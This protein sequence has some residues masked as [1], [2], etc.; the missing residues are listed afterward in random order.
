M[1][2]SVTHAETE[3]L[4]F[5]CYFLLTMDDPPTGAN[6]YQS[7]D[8]KIT[9]QFPSKPLVIVQDRKLVDEVVKLTVA[10]VTYSPLDPEGWGLM[11]YDFKEPKKGKQQR[12]D[13]RD[14]NIDG[15]I[16]ARK[17]K[18]IEARTFVLRE[19]VGKDCFF[20]T[21]GEYHRVQVYVSEHRIIILM[22]KTQS[23][24]DLS[25]KKATDFFGSIIL[26]K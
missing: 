22:F 24:S 11:W 18:L 7:P 14:G 16:D 21:K 13:C 15:I 4:V 17:G 6:H 20:V 10:A 19:Y 2:G 3:M 25:G 5:L 12:Q 9:I 8:K 1:Q 23:K 26:K